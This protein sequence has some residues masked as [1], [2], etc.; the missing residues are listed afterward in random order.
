MLSGEP[1]PV[2][3]VSIY[4]CGGTRVNLSRY[5]ISTVITAVLLLGG[6][7]SA[8]ELTRS[9][10]PGMPSPRASISDLKW[11][12]GTWEG[13]G[14]AGADAVE[15]Y[16]TAKGGQM[17]GHF[18]QLNPDGTIFFY[19]LMTI[20]EKDGTLHYRL[21]HFNA[22]LTGWE[23]KEVVRDFPLVAVDKDT[24]YFDDLTLKRDGENGM[25]AGVRVQK[26]DGATMEL[27]FHYIRKQH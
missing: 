23:E 21:K 24:W 17:V 11:L 7:T 15:V 18:R 13:K 5:C 27:S 1:E 22:D 26:K 16:S 19:E 3:P 8:Q 10:R 2:L 4:Q 25:I 9:A 6:I 12:E 20:T 14:I